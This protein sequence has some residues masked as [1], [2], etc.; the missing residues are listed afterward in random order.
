MHFACLVFQRLPTG[1]LAR[2][3][4]R[5]DRDVSHMM[6]EESTME[7]SDTDRQEHPVEGPKID[8]PGLSYWDRLIQQVQKTVDEAPEIREDRVAAMKRA[9]QDGTLNLSG[10]DLAEKLLG[11]ILRDSE[12]G[13]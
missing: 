5:E 1:V 11:E 9:L 3:H 7:G 10:K 8:K 4:A 6:R 12:R 13:A 2:E